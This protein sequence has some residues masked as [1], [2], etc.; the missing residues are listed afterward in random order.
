MGIPTSIRLESVISN[1]THRKEKAF[2]KEKGLSFLSKA[3]GYPSSLAF[4]S[5][6]LVHSLLGGWPSVPM[7][8][9]SGDGF[10]SST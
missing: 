5:L 6:R 3:K 7:V 9:S 4:P 10:S 1:I 8:R 2:C